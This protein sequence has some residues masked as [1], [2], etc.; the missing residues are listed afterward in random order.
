ME[1]KVCGRHTENE[2]ANFCEY[3]GTSFRENYQP[4]YLEKQN[5]YE[6]NQDIKMDN[7]DK[8]ITF[9]NW[10]GSLLLPFIPVIGPFIYLIM[11]F[12][13][14]FGSEAPQSKKNWAKAQ[15]IITLISIVIVVYFMGTTMSSIMNSSDFQ[16]IY[17]SL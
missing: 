17:N 14:S 11:L 12:V 1:C 3:C 2:Y 15:L 9:G 6:N 7:N 13:W 16:Q 8:S 4:D 10:M 5:Q